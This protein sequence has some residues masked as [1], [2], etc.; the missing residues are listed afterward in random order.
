MQESNGRLGSNLRSYPDARLAN[1]GAD[2]GGEE[3]GAVAESAPNRH[4]LNGYLA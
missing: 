2:T 1:G 3:G 4:R